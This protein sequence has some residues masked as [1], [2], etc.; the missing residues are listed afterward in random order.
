MTKID[1]TITDR[2]NGI[3]SPQ[4]P[5]SEIDPAIAELSGSTISLHGPRHLRLRAIVDR[6]F[7]PL[8]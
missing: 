4:V 6:A 1:L 3:Q 2:A 7:T 5:L 8:D